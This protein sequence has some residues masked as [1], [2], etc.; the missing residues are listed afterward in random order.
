MPVALFLLILTFVSTAGF[1]QQP[2]DQ[3]TAGF[4]RDI[5]SVLTKPRL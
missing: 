2:G 1:A 3:E 4:E 5:V